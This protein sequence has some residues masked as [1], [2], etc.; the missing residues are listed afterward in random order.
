MNF[1][2]IPEKFANL[3]SL[4]LVCEGCQMLSIPQIDTL[5]T[6]M[7]FYYS[8]TEFEIPILNSLE[9][10]LVADCSSLVSLIGLDHQPNLKSFSYAKCVKFKP[11][12][13]V[14]FKTERLS[15]ENCRLLT[16]TTFIGKQFHSLE[17]FNT[18]TGV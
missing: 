12:E 2:L 15:E 3:Q 1:N 4:F 7:V 16:D 18:T 17:R 13:S 11:T 9:E 8:G 5:K 14:K 10:L 6:L